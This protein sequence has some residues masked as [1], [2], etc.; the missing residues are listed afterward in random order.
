MFSPPITGLAKAT[1][2][3]LFGALLLLAACAASANPDSP[4]SPRLIEIEQ[5]G[6][7]EAAKAI[8]DAIEIGLT[9]RAGQ[10]GRAPGS[11]DF[12]RQRPIVRDAHPKAHGCV[13][14][15]FRVEAGL[16]A[17]LAQGAFKPGSSYC[18]WVR[19]SNSNEDPD[20]SD[21]LKD[22]RGMAIKLLGVP[23]EP[24]LPAHKGAGTQDFIMI[25]HPVFFIDDVKDYATLVQ[26]QNKE[27]GASLLK[28]F[29]A[30]G[31]KGTLNALAITS[32]KN[33]NPLE[34]EYWSMVPYRLGTGDKAKVI[35]FKSQPCGFEDLAEREKAYYR[36]PEIP[37]SAAPKF[38]R[39]AL[40]SSMETGSPCMEFLVQI[41][42][43]PMS[44]EDAKTEW[45]PE[46]APFRKVATLRFPEGQNFDTPE[47]NLACEDMAFDPWHASVEH[48]PLG[49]LNRIRKEVYQRISSF[50]RAGNRASQQEPPAFQLDQCSNGLWRR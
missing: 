21:A 45:S 16:P 25:S 23:N 27:G 44:V 26:E 6:E 38:L 42:V 7:K 31:I 29:S 15:N 8:G 14:A 17:E 12:A 18:S 28:L 30:I 36:N 2:F 43:E 1:R 33:R 11:D 20:R 46:I 13:K 24:L 41:G 9:R 3:A 10:R 40:K 19:F 35:K 37:D 34:G 5:D 22:G 50:R 4:M 39:Q 49:A 47:Q 32:L 48:Q